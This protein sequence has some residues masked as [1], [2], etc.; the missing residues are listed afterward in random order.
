MLVLYWLVHMCLVCELSQAGDIPD[1]EPISPNP[2]TRE[3]DG[4]IN[5]LSTRPLCLESLEK[6]PQKEVPGTGDRFHRSGAGRDSIVSALGVSDTKAMEYDRRVAPSKSSSNPFFAA[7]FGDA[8]SSWQFLDSQSDQPRRHSGD[9]TVMEKQIHGGRRQRNGETSRISLDHHRHRRET[10]AQSRGVDGHECPCLSDSEGKLCASSSDDSSSEESASVRKKLDVL[11][12]TSRPSSGNR[13][14]L[15]VGQENL[16]VGH[17]VRTGSRL[18][19]SPTS[20]LHRGNISDDSFIDKR[21]LAQQITCAQ[22]DAAELPIEACCEFPAGHG[23][24]APTY[25]KGE[26]SDIAVSSLYLDRQTTSQNNESSS[27]ERSYINCHLFEEM[28]ESVSATPRSTNHDEANSCDNSLDEIMTI[29]S[30][31]LQSP[32]SGIRTPFSDH[33]SPFRPRISSTSGSGTLDFI[34]SLEQDLRAKKNFFPGA[35]FSDTP[36]CAADTAT[37]VSDQASI[38]SPMNIGNSSRLPDNGQR[39]NRWKKSMLMGILSASIFTLKKCAPSN[40]DLKNLQLKSDI[41]RSQAVRS[42]NTPDSEDVIRSS[43]CLLDDMGKIRNANTIVK[44]TSEHSTMENQTAK[45]SASSSCRQRME[46][47]GDSHYIPEPESLTGY[48]NDS[49]KK[50]FGALEI[51]ISDPKDIFRSRL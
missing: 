15:K 27:D 51:D 4:G 38:V 44:S 6:P 35:V 12:K 5:L 50:R 22:M 18:A 28:S 41:T 48:L 26:S 13:L 46:R 25:D 14:H 3:F 30:V 10:S 19:T 24:T 2:G 39:E 29:R 17:K 1:S 16:N 34:M 7:P 36:S 8:A 31:S 43:A 33:G 42:C 20:F 23:N 37:G 45:V 21:S 32:A 11:N 40:N 47:R 49:T 9:P